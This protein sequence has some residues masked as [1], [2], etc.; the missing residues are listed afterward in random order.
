MMK[1]DRGASL[2]EVIVVL[3]LI[4]ALMGLVGVSAVAAAARYQ[5]KAVATELASELRM[6]R[7]LALVRRERMRVVFDQERMKI[8]TVAADRPDEVIREYG[9]QGK[10]IVFERLSNGPALVFYP[11][12]R[13][14][15]PATIIFRNKQMERWQLTVSLTGRVSF[16]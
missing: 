14:A 12:G 15:T 13:S 9:Y 16:L 11:S 3:G 10:G 2:V 1:N 6:A 8:R 5:G 7:Y 4:G